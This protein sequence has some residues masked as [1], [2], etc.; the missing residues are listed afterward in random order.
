MHE[1]VAGEVDHAGAD[2]RDVDGRI[3]RAGGGGHEQGLAAAGGAHVVER[4]FDDEGL[5]LDGCFG[6]VS[7]D[8]IPFGFGFRLMVP[9][10][11]LPLMSGSVT[12][13]CFTGKAIQSLGAAHLW[14]IGA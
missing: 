10:D 11:R 1:G 9:I 6:V 12:P 8:G 5:A 14:G 7:H 2:I 13:N 4:E 3:G